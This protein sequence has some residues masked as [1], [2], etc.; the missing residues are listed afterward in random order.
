MDLIANAPRLPSPG[1]SVLGSDFAMYPGGKGGNQAVAAAQQGAST[2]IVARVGDDAFGNQLR[3]SLAG[4]QVDV[5]LLQVDDAEAT[6]V[7][8]VL[9]GSDGEYASI[10]VPGASLA[11]TPAHLEPAHEALRSCDVLMLQ[12]EIG[13]AV[14]AAAAFLA[15]SAGATVVINVAPAAA[16]SHASRWEIWRHVDLV[17][18]N[19]D[20][21]EAL[22]GVVVDGAASG[23]RAAKGLRTSLGVATVIVTLGAAGAVLADV[24]GE[25]DDPGYDV[26]VLDTIGAGDAFAGSVAAA[27]ARGVGLREAVRLGNA[28]AALA[29]GRRGAFDACPTLAEAELFAADVRRGI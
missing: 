24:S 18:A 25:I 10:V 1:E 8:P 5:S 20:E 22:S 6:G 17:I 29:V 12:L 16:L 11:L 19:R 27:L 9:M 13:M 28:A 3:E 26:E 7:S 21:A 4:K 23:I 2:A 14:S 15:R